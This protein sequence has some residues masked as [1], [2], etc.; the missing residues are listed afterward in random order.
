MGRLGF[1][2]LSGAKVRCWRPPGAATAQPYHPWF[3]FFVSFVSTLLSFIRGLKS[4]CITGFAIEKLKSF[5][6]FLSSRG[7]LLCGVPNFPCLSI[8]YCHLRKLACIEDVI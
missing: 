3:E 8:V 5:L 2:W 4:V 1:S 7:D 6:A